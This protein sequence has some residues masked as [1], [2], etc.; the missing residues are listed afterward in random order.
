MMNASEHQHQSALIQW[1]ELMESK[2]PELKLL[3][4]IPNG[5]KRDV[6]GA[7]NLKREG[8]KPGVPDLFLPVAR[9]EYHG[10][11]I[12]LKTETGKASTEQLIW[13]DELIEQKYCATV[14]HGWGS[15][16]KTIEWYMR[17]KK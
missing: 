15:A 7:V 12:E 13:I 4:A 8:V 11:F 5:G 1:A 10:L 9:G 2:Y 16:A 6:I 17:M 3:H 14:C